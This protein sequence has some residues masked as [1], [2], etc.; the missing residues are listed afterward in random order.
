MFWRLGDVGSGAAAGDQVTCVFVNAFPGGVCGVGS[1]SGVV[2]G[3]L[4]LL[5]GGKFRR[6]VGFVLEVDERS[7]D[8]PLN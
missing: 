2:R 8:T 3:L 7:R 5:E 4:G 1:S 6:G